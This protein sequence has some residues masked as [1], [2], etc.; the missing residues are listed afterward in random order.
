MRLYVGRLEI[1]NSR[2]HNIAMMAFVTNDETEK[3][4]LML[5]RESVIKLLNGKD[6]KYHFLISFSSEMLMKW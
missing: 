1:L 4:R 3:K 5:Q 2:I 6:W